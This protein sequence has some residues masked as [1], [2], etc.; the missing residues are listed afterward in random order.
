MK[1]VRYVF[2]EERKNVGVRQIFVPYVESGSWHVWNQ[3]LVFVLTQSRMEFA[4]HTA[5]S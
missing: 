4:F 2:E 3:V 5:L 1:S